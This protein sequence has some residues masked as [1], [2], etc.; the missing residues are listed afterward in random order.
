MDRCKLHR[1]LL[2][3]GPAA[4]SFGIRFRETGLVKRG[5]EPPECPVEF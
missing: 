5:G 1:K 4:G 3:A 2:F